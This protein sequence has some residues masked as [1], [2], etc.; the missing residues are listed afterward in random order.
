M[1]GGAFECP[2]C[3]LRLPFRAANHEIC[4]RC[5]TQFGEDDDEVSHEELRQRWIRAGC[6]WFSRSVSA[7][8]YLKMERRLAGS[9]ADESEECEKLLLALDKCAVALDRLLGITDPRKGRS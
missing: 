8:D 1:R 6:P 4:F 3:W 7:L 9:G 5:G 2:V